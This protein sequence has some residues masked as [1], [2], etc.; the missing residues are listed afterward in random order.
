[1]D[2]IR[3]F[4]FLCVVSV[5]FFLNSGFYDHVVEGGSMLLMTALRN[6]FMICV[7]LFMILSGYLLKDKIPCKSYYARIFQTLGIYLLA[8]IACAGYEFLFNRENF[9]A[10][11]S[12]L[13]LF[14]F[15]TAPY[16]WYIEMYI[17]LFLIIPFLNRMYNGMTQKMKKLLIAMFLVLTALPSIMNIWQF[18]NPSWWLRPAVSQNYDFLVPDYWIELYPITYYFIGC[19]LREYPIKLK[20]STNFFLI[21]GVFA[22]SGAFNAYRSIGD[23]F[24]EG[25]WSEH[26]SFFVTIQSVLVFN[27]LNRI[28]LSRVGERTGIVLKKLSSWTLGAYLCSSIFD[29]YFY[30]ILKTAEPVMERRILYFPIIVLVVAICSLVLSAVLNWIYDLL[31]SLLAFVRKKTKVH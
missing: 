21:V 30:K 15:S 13:G 14:T 4:A 10:M 22:V 12:V 6:F 2:V 26:R 20:S 25:S 27:F 28:N 29:D 16:S 31:V 5:H 19:Y 17:G 8:S 23:V 18:F 24:V 11:G 7:P 9:S 1:M 3:I